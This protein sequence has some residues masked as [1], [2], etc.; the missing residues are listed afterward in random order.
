MDRDEV[1]ANGSETVTQPRAVGME[2]MGQGPGMFLK[3][4]SEDFMSS[5]MNQKMEQAFRSWLG[6][7]LS[8]RPCVILASMSSW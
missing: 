5:W 3:S 7:V 6:D 2:E 8:I 4:D 1:R